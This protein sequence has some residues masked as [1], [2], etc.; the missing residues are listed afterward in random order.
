MAEGAKRLPIAAATLSASVMR[1]GTREVADPGNCYAQHREVDRQ[2][3]KRAGITNESDMPRRDR[4]HAL[5]VPHSGAGAWSQPAPPSGRRRGPGTQPR[6]R[7]HREPARG[8]PNARA[9]QRFPRPAP[10]WLERGARRAGPGRS[11]SRWLRRGRDARGDGRRPQPSRTRRSGR[12]GARTQRA[13]RSRA[14]RAHRRGG[15]CHVEIEGLGGAVEQQQ[16]A[17]RL[18]GRDEDEQLRIGGSW[19]RRRA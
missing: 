15:C 14:A 19:T 4:K 1:G 9:R 5:V 11:R 3:R 2:L 13:H 7:A 10:M 8:Q 17:E 16:V 12:V 6:R 18:R